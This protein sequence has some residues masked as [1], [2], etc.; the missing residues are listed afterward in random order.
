MA[1]V[2]YDDEVDRFEPLLVEGRVYYVWRMSAEPVMRNQ[3]YMFADS[4]FVCRFTSVT[5]LNEIRNV[6]EQFIPLFP[7]FM[8]FDKVW[9]FTLDNDMYVGKCFS[10][11]LHLPNVVFNKSPINFFLFKC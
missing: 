10:F 8:P 2:I 4:H 1:A 3:D 11:F 6:N 9:Q 7:P 5:A